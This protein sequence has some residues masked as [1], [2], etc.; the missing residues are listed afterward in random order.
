MPAQ[1]LHELRSAASHLKGKQVFQL[2]KTMPLEQAAIHQGRHVAIAT[3]L[4]TLAENYQFDEIVS[5]L[6]FDC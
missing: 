3:Q 6:D 4:Q 5:L 2:V 1:W